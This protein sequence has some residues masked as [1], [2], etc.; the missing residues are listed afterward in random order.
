MVPEEWEVIELGRCCN[1]V[2]GGSPRPKEDPKYFSKLPT[3][4]HWITISDLSKFRKGKCLTN[5]SEYLTEAG[6]KKSRYLK[7]G[8]LVLA[9]SGSVGIPAI[10]EI[11]GCIHDGYLAFLNIEQK[12][13]KEYL[14]FLFESLTCTHII[15]P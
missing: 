10:L 15:G 14:Y 13:I 7:A 4:I 9:N 5:T 6:I 11:N 1:V 2:R 3:D 8:E 12:L